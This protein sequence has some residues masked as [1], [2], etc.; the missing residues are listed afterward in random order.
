MDR[1]ACSI[2]VDAQEIKISDIVTIEDGVKVLYFW[3]S[4]AVSEDTTIVH[5][6][7]KPGNII[8]GVKL[9]VKKS[10]RFRTYSRIIAKPGIYTVDVRDPD[11]NPLPGG[12]FKSITILPSE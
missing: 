4:I 5:V 10:P 11:S 8:N 12:E 9:S 3:T 7:S 6:W 2:P 1:P